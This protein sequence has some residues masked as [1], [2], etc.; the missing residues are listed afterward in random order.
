MTK[1]NIFGVNSAM[2]III[3]TRWLVA[4]MYMTTSPNGNIFRVTGPLCREFTG[5]KDQWRGALMYSLICFWISGWVKNHE[6]GDL[7]RHRVHYDVTVMETGIYWTGQFSAKRALVSKKASLWLL[8]TLTSRIIWIYR[9]S[10]LSTIILAI[11][12][13]TP[14]MTVLHKLIF[15]FIL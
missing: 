15:Q 11:I 5:H 14:N 2:L 12:Q 3:Y 1:N 7:K 10:Y 8:R 6:A 9:S 13:C 4:I